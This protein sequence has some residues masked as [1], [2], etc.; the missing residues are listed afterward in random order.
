MNTPV[1]VWFPLVLN[2]EMSFVPGTGL[3]APTSLKVC[4]MTGQTAPA[5][6]TPMNSTKRKLN[7]RMAGDMERY[8]VTN[9]QIAS[10]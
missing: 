4:A 7:T 8:Y 3:T 1:S 10:R 2:C 6:S 5:D 9:G